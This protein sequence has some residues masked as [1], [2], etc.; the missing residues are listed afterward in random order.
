MQPP[1]ASATPD[2]QHALARARIQI[3]NL[4]GGGK[5][6]LLPATRNFGEKIITTILLAVFAA[7]FAGLIFFARDFTG[8]LPWAWARFLVVNILFYP[9]A[10]MGLI[11]AVFVI[12]C[13]DTWLRSSRVIASGGELR[14][15]TRW[16]FVRRMEVIPAA[17]IIR[18]RAANNTTTNETKYYDI[19]VVST[20]ERPG[21]F[22]KL[23]PPT[24]VKDEIEAQRIRTGGKKFA[25]MTSVQGEAE[26]EWILAQLRAALNLTV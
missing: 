3:T 5:E 4:P 25:A 16:L 26:A 17:K 9:V 8:A 2:L 20:G 14:V 23:F 1:A 13:G 12:V 22:F 6:F 21:W 19:E 15:E 18:T 7:I 10:V 11:S 24:N